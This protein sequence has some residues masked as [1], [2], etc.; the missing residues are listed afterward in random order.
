MVALAHDRSVNDD[1]SPGRR[2]LRIVVADDD[3]DTVITLA[4]VLQHEG[5]EVREVYRGDAVLRLI[6]EFKP[7]ACLLDIGMPGVSGY[8]LARLLRERYGESC[9]LLIAIT[10]LKKP[11]E[12]LL[13]QIVGFHHY[14]TKPYSTE[15]LLRLLAPLGDVEATIPGGPPAPTPEQRLLVQ[16]AHLIGHKELADALKV[17]ESLLESWIEGRSTIPHR[18]LVSLADALIDMASKLAKK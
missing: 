17:T 4:T 18:H 6:D 2:R 11:S 5:H 1:A 7:D 12:R 3:R 15:E 16:A 9:P 14:V 13:G 10:G 8:E